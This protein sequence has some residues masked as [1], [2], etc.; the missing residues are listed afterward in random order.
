MNRRRPRGIPP[1][2]IA[3]HAATLIIFALLA[4]VVSVRGH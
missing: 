1:E 2:I 4:L 3:L